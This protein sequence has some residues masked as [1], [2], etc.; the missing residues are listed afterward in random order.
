[1]SLH[2]NSPQKKWNLFQL[3]AWQRVD[4]LSGWTGFTYNWCLDE[5]AG[6]ANNGLDEDQWPGFSGVAARLMLTHDLPVWP[7]STWTWLALGPVGLCQIWMDLCSWT[8]QQFS[9]NALMMLTHTRSAYVTFLMGSLGLWWTSGTLSNR[10]N[11]PI[12]DWSMW[13]WCGLTSQ[14]QLIEWTASSPFSTRGGPM[15]FNTSSSCSCKGSFGVCCWTSTSR[16]GVAF[17]PFQDINLLCHYSLLVCHYSFF[18]PFCSTLH[19]FSIF[20]N[21]TLTAFIKS[22]FSA[23]KKGCSDMIHT[24]HIISYS[25]R[26]PWCLYRK[27]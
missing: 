21:S 24:Y 18:S 26:H 27:T 13:P 3:G 25:T 14:D 1:M 4:Q 6:Y 2:Q 10:S 15:W 7:A 9:S 23:K 20:V 12:H 16:P 19:Q 8:E 17:L 22:S 5:W 11:G